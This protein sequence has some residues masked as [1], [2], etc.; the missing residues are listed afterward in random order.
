MDTIYRVKAAT[1]ALLLQAIAAPTETT[2]GPGR[3]M[4][5]TEPGRT[6][7]I[8]RLQADVR[9]FDDRIEGLRRARAVGLSP[10]CAAGLDS[11][12]GALNRAMGRVEAL[13]RATDGTWPSALAQAEA[14][15]A[16]LRQSVDRVAAN[17]CAR[18]A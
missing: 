4:G 15:L 7:R 2:I 3:E 8:Q 13:H 14:A 17:A 12:R 5:M 1:L 9:A 18:A 16:D 6:A 11:L 10:E